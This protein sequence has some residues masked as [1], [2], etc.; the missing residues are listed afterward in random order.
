MPIYNLSRKNKL[1]FLPLVAWLLCNIWPLLSEFFKL[2]F[3]SECLTSLLPS[4]TFPSVSPVSCVSS[5]DTRSVCLFTV[6][7]SDG[8]SFLGISLFCFV[9]SIFFEEFSFSEWWF[10]SF[11]W[12]FLIYPLPC[13]K[14]LWEGFLWLMESTSL[15]WLLELYLSLENLK[16]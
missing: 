2:P 1:N 4:F 15:T 14:F 5:S 11:G 7:W 8:S 6:L 3:L 16:L 10:R 13:L 9:L 12:T